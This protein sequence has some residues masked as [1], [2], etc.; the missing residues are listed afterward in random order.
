M[1]RVYCKE[2][3][4]K[5]KKKKNN[6]FVAFWSS[7]F[8]FSVAA[9]GLQCAKKDLFFQERAFWR[10]FPVDTRVSLEILSYSTQELP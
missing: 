3:K 6:L 7:P 1:M 10:T 8:K 9:R 4:K 2:Q 5:E